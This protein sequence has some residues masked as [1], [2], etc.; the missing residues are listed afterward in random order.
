MSENT[1]KP[2]YD[3]CPLCADIGLK[4]KVYYILYGETVR[5]KKKCG[6]H[7]RDI[8]RCLRGKISKDVRKPNVPK[9]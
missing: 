1:L 2:A 7:P 4:T 5:I 9:P 3:F 6:H 8:S